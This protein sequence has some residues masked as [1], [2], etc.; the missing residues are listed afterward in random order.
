MFYLKKIE[1]DVVTGTGVVGFKKL[2]IASFIAS[3]AD[4]N[5]P[6]TTFST[7]IKIT[8]FRRI[9]VTSVNK[10]RSQSTRAFPLKWKE[11]CLQI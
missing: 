9:V 1:A 3:I 7:T 6:L 10:F 11:M 4:D 2:L 5:P 8:P